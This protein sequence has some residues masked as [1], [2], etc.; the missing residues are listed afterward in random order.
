M[1]NFYGIFT[2]IFLR[3]FGLPTKYLYW[4]RC[5]NICIIRNLYQITQEI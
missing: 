3:G 4:W 2:Y 5:S 1:V